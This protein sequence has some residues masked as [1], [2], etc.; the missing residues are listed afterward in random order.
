MKATSLLTI[1]SSLTLG[2]LTGFFYRDE[3]VFPT[4]MRIKMAIIEH[5]MLTRQ[6]LNTDRA[7]SARRH[8]SRKDFAITSS[9]TVG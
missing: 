4:N 9:P 2:T 3:L 6:K 8:R 7:Q 5:H 1:T